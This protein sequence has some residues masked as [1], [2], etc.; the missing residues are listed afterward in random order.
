MHLGGSLKAYVDVHM[1]VASAAWTALPAFPLADS[2]MEMPTEAPT[3]GTNLSSIPTVLLGNV[4]ERRRLL[5]NATKTMYAEDGGTDAVGDVVILQEAKYHHEP[6][7]RKF[8]QNHTL[9][10]S[11]LSNYA[12]QMEATKS[13]QPCVSEKDHNFP[14]S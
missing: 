7:D 3:A 13:I 8:L 9:S 11:H 5:E 10:L 4:G 6:L 1:Q 2:S 12:A 14:S